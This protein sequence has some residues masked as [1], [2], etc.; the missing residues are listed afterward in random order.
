M[1]YY[2]KFKLGYAEEGTYRTSVIDGVGDTAYL[3]GAFARAA[4]HPSATYNTIPVGPGFNSL[5]VA[6][7]MMFESE[8]ELRGH[9]T[10]RAQNGIPC[11]MTMGTS[12][13]A[14]A[15][16]YTHT[17]TPYTDGT[18]LPSFT[19]NLEEEGTATDEEFQWTGCKV[20]SMVLSHDAKTANCL[21]YEMEWMAGKEADGI[22][23]TTAPQL[24]PTA[25]TDAYIALERKYD[26]SSANLDIDGLQRVD[27]IIGNGLEPVYSHSTDAGT[28][29]GEWPYM[30]LEAPMKQYEIQMLLHP[31]TIE[32]AIWDDKRN[33]VNTKDYTFKWTR[34]TNDYIKVTATNCHPVEHEKMTPVA[35]KESMLVLVRLV[36]EA[37]SIEVKDSIAGGTYYG[38]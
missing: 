23:L 33:H 3:M 11:W 14:G 10:I 21:I 37:I 30:Y 7:G 32:R 34:S 29:T 1:G 27:I 22:A 16:P 36:P 31:S 19:L 28:Y 38:E 24:P 25:N 4:K 12:S 2:D 18:L 6:A 15:D 8:A 5:E 26:I 17:I 13:T 9:Y 35:K 20:D